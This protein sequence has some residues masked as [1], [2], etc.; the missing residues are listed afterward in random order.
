MPDQNVTMTMEGFQEVINQMNYLQSSRVNNDYLIPSM[1]SIGGQVRKVE[2]GNIPRFTSKT[3]NSLGSRVTAVGVGSV[4]LT[5]GPGS[6]RKYIFR[7]IDG[8]AQWHDRASSITTW[9]GRENNR[10]IRG[11]Q[12]TKSGSKANPSYLPVNQLL[13]W[14]RQKLGVSAD[15]ALHVAF[16]VAKTLGREGLKPR[17]ITGPTVGQV[18]QMVINAINET[19]RKM[20]EGLKNNG[21]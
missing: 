12:R 16:R 13:P 4:M 5:V 1:K 11:E 3:A 8:G 17:P 9:R 18:K 2:K 19:I 10:N 21:K 15:E 7:Y 14:V 20:V 6:K